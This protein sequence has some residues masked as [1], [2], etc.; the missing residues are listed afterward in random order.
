[1]NQVNRLVID[2][3]YFPTINYYITLYRYTDIIFEQ[4][5]YHRK[6]SFRN[7]CSIAGAN[8]PI[9]L[10]VPIIGGREQRVITK[11]VKIDNSE[12]WQIQHW[13]SVIS[14]Y[15]R[16]PFFEH[17]EEDLRS[18]YGRKFTFL[19]D[20]NLACMNWLEINNVK[21]RHF[22]CTSGY[23]KVYDPGDFDDL[24]DWFFP[25]WLEERVKNPVTYRQVFEDKNGFIP[26][27]SVLDFLFCEGPQRLNQLQV[28]S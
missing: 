24:R 15:N 14:S 25:R 17:F 6:M 18:L 20:W 1:M 5:D 27:L 12:K 7:R 13:R 26:N 28:K 3:Q 21:N 19:L 23:L 16:S 22:T 4:Y 9:N 8:G 2:L 11:D 10:S